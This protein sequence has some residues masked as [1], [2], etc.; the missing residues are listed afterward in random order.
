VFARSRSGGLT[1]LSGTAGCVT[2]D[3]S[4]GT[5]AAVAGLANLMDIA[6]SPDGTRVYVIATSSDALIQFARD[7]T[8]GA[9]T[10]LV[11]F[12]PNGVFTTALTSNAVAEFDR[13]GE[14][15]AE[16]ACFAT[17]DGGCTSQPKL[18]GIQGVAVSHDGA[19][20][21]VAAH[22]DD[23]VSIFR[24]DTVTTDLSYQGCM[25]PTTD[26]TPF[27]GMDGV[28]AVAISPDDRNL[29][30]ASVDDNANGV[31]AAFA[32][33]TVVGSTLGVLRQLPGT[34]GCLS[35]NGNADPTYDLGASCTKTRGAGTPIRL[36]VAPDGH[37]VYAP[38]V[39]HPSLAVLSRSAGG[40]LTEPAGT[41][42]CVSED[43][44]N[45]CATGHTLSVAVGAAVA[46]GVGAQVYVASGF[47]TD[48]GL[49]IFDRHLYPN[50]S[51]TS[52]P[53]PTTSDRTPTFRFTSTDPGSTFQ[54]KVGSAS[55]HRCTSP[56]TTG[57]L[58]LGRHT[59]Y[60]RATNSAGYTDPSAARRTFKVV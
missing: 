19:S 38:A 5:C 48:Q 57:K 47:S 3:G 60:V 4:G 31:I 50:T 12:N 28:R 49:A 51:I 17:N 44:S 29:Y 20:L 7:T 27:L 8:T 21:Y 45:G 52:G 6:V 14:T 22:G 10:F 42:G 40:A 59:V 2:A 53:K 1:P 43:G 25:G 58:R 54:C 30:T 16:H 18:S 41:G 9:L 36:E 11:C 35:D 39:G 15:L 37:S 56:F 32:R 23:T 26:C 55:Y 34:A 46:P 33:S 24:R 13:S